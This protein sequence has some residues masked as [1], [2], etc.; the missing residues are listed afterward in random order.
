MCIIIG[1]S[2]CFQVWPFRTTIINYIKHKVIMIEQTPGVMGTCQRPFQDFGFIFTAEAQQK[3]VVLY[4]IFY[5]II[6]VD[7]YNVT[8]FLPSSNLSLLF[9][10]SKFHKQRGRP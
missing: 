10:L 5:D 6:E 7:I 4:D 9:H 2:L 8:A 1:F 3:T